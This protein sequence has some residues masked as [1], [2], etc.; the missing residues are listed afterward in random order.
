MFLR[1]SVV[2]SQTKRQTEVYYSIIYRI[3]NLYI[4]QKLNCSSRPV[5]IVCVEQ[6][7]MHYLL[8]LADRFHLILA[9]IAGVSG[10]PVR[11]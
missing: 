2:Q 7:A 8:V 6:V 4:E 9:Q 10:K 3:L 5:V 11:G 1:S